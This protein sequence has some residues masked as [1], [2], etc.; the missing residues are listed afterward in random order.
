MD[1][2]MVSA[3]EQNATN[4]LKSSHDVSFRMFLV[5][6]VSGRHVSIVQ[7]ATPSCSVLMVYPHELLH[8]IKRHASVGVYM[9][10]ADGIMYCSTKDVLHWVPFIWC[11][12]L[13]RAIVTALHQE[14][15][16]LL[17]LQHERGKIE[18]AG[19]ILCSFQGGGWMVQLFVCDD[20]S[21][22]TYSSTPSCNRKRKCKNE[23]GINPGWNPVGEFHTHPPGEKDYV[24]KPPS[25]YD[26]YQLLLA[27]G[28]GFHNFLATVC[29]EGLYV[30][31]GSREAVASIMTDLHRYYRLPH[32]GKEMTDQ[33]ISNHNQWAFLFKCTLNTMLRAV[34]RRWRWCLPLCHICTVFW[35]A[36]RTRTLNY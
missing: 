6:D 1:N 36:W 33:Q 31:S 13:F 20:T 4:L 28:N 24:C 18:I 7:H 34:C 27:A 16:S 2:A 17:L 23:N 25:N 30:V 8:G 5:S 26:I 11:E 12:E 21:A 19:D 10:A 22:E 32:T 9:L 15:T 3:I 29:Q 14:H 35:W